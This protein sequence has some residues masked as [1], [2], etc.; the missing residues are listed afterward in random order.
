[1]TTDEQSAYPW[2]KPDTIR[3]NFEKLTE[4]SQTELFRRLKEIEII[5]HN[6]KI[7]EQRRKNI[8]SFIRIKN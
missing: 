1:M 6:L 5:V 2:E 3:Y 7:E 8:G 4:S